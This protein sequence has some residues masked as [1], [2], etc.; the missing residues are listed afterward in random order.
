M[1]NTCSIP[2]FGLPAG[3]PPGTWS[4]GRTPVSARVRRRRLLLAATVVA[5]LVVLALPWGGTGGCSLATP[6]TARG[7][8]LVAGSYYVVRPGDTIWGIATRLS[9]GSDPQPVVAEL[10]SEAGGDHVAPGQ[11]LVLP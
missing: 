1:T 7:G 11:V 9:G 2:A 10:E 5:L 6:G 4:A 3:A 8:S